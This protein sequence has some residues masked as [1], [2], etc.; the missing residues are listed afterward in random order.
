MDTSPSSANRNGIWL[1]V[2]YLCLSLGII[3]L[4]YNFYDLKYPNHFVGDM[5]GLEVMF[6]LAVLSGVAVP[7]L[8][9]GV[10]IFVG[11]RKK[12]KRSLTVGTAV[13]TVS[14]AILI[15]MAIG[16]AHSRYMDEVRKSYPSKSIEELLAIAREQK[17]QQ[18]ID[19][20][21]TRSDPAAMPGLASI[22]MDEQEPG[23]LRYVA[24]EALAR[25]GSDD[26]RTVLENARDS[27]ADAWFKEILNR[28]VED[29]SRES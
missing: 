18:A 29:M 12:V 10:L 1:W 27:C 25:I 17:D 4:L 22:V 15:A 26:A 20:I 28:L 11:G 21:M 8:I 6:R 9:G 5:Y 16:V 14:S 19:Q 3:A 23:Y 2:G 7:M 13:T 24:A